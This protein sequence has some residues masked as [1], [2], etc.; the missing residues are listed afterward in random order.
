M[1][2]DGEDIASSHALQNVEIEAA[3]LG[4]RQLRT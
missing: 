2:A 4:A 3:M 1:D